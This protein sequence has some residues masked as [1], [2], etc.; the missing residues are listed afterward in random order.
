[1]PYRASILPSGGLALFFGVIFPAG[2]IAFELATGMCANALFDP[3]P[4]PWH[5]LLVASVPLVNLLLWRR[6]QREL[7]PPGWLIVAAGGAVAIGTSYTLL[8]LP[9]LPI[10]VIAIVFF[11]IGLLPYAPLVATIATVHFLAQFVGQGTRLAARLLGGAALGL[12]LL[13]LADLPATATFLAIDGYRGD[14]K[15]QTNSVWL[16][17][18]LGDRD[19]LLRLAY[20]DTGRAT[21]LVSFLITSWGR[22]LDGRLREDYS[23]DARELYYRVTGTPFNAVAAPTHGLDD[24]R[25]WFM[26]W[27]QDQGGSE[28]GRR[29]AGLMLATSRIDGSVASADNLGYFEWT[30]EVS[31][32]DEL[33]HEARMTIALPEG[34]VASRATLWVNGEP[35]EASVAGRGETRAAY[36]RVVRAQRDPL[37]VTT[38]G[39]QRLLVQ[40]FPV[41]SRGTLKLRIGYSAP[42][43]VAADG[44]RSLALPAIVERN[45]DV[46]GDLRHSV[47]IEGDAMLASGDSS[48]QPGGAGNGLHGEPS[49]DYLLAH[50]PRILAS[51]LSAPL[52]ATGSVAALDKAPGIAVEQTVAPVPASAAQ[53]LTIVLDGSLSGAK[54]GAALREALGSLPNGMPVSLRIAAET[55][56]SVAVAPWSPAQKARFDRAI[57]GT[58]FVGGQDNIPALGDALGGM[59]DGRGTIL[60]IHG[61]QPVAFE[62]TG[63]RVEQMLERSSAL[64]RLVRYQPEAGRAFTIEGARWFDTAREATPSGDTVRDLRMIFAELGNGPRWTTERHEVAE[65]AEPRSAHIVRL[66]G[67][68]QVAAA[69][70]E[71][72][73]KRKAAVALA[74]RLNLITPLSGAVVL[75]SDKDTQANDLPVPSAENVPTVPEPHEWALLVVLAAMLG[76]VFRGRLP[77]LR[78]ARLG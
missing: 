16:M 37:L 40:A 45:F 29:V 78:L 70:S 25:R 71:R 73:D 52:V 61:P 67:A 1:M 62:R 10:A 22:G 39:A 11:G 23:G 6:V 34:A 58:R 24:R 32:D 2:V 69:E 57:A 60:W 28:I 9:V 68:D 14:P 63:A 19:V 56:A 30:L 7:D 33:Q 54:A 66:W 21:G 74:G 5:L 3:M 13:A 27:D 53:P 44:T 72:G 31:N 12:L 77:K 64:P 43:Q 4:T 38:D 20:G 46:G 55:P 35:R 41:E 48:L 75:E 47:W 26:A 76:W 18:N 8:L 42:F 15:A 65:A 49:D 36:Q 59:L 17:R 51:K 50:R